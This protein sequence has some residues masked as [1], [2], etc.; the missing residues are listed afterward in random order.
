MLHLA[1]LQLVAG[2]LG[3]PLHG[4]PPEDVA[5]LDL[6]DQV[7]HDPLVVALNLTRPGYSPQAILVGACNRDEVIGLMTAKAR[8]TVAG[9]MTTKARAK[10]AGMKTTKARDTVTG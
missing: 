9:L 7:V 10:V 3:L 6:V 1:V 8:D 2:S 5:S 4:E